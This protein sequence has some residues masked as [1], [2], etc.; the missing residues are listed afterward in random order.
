MANQSLATAGTLRKKTPW[1]RF[2]T[3]FKKSWQLHLMLLLPLAYIIIFS[4]GP[5]YGLQ[6]AFRDYRTRAGL[7]GSEWVGLY[8]YTTFF[9][10]YKWSSYVWNTFKI[11]SYSIL[12]GFP[13]PIIL[14]LFIHSNNNIVLRKLTQNVSYIPHFIST[15]V[16]VG[17][18]NKV[19]DPFIGVWGTLCRELGVM[20]IIDLRS[21]PKAFIHL[22]VWSGV[23][24]NMG[25]GAILYV[26]A[27]SAVSPELHEAARIDGA[28]R[29]RRLLSVDLPAILPTICIMLIMRM[30]GI[31]NVGYEKVYLMQNNLNITNSEV[32]STY[33]YKNGL[34]NNNLSY[35]SAVGMMNSVVGTSMVVLV[36]WIT[37]KLS[38]GEAGLF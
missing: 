3:N 33:V 26:S 25:W 18:L 10:N 36:N 2:I 32:I 27:L 5:M 21:N 35:G 6:I 24:Q 13:V 9:S 17:I 34:A 8:Q 29:F 16:M 22:Y 1:Q 20:E 31:L 23:W 12:A 4:Y 7:T 11:A 14:A 28:S 15:V 30:G 37:N 19:L 38:D